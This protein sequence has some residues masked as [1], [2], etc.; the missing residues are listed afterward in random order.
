VHAPF[1]SQV[2]REN[3]NALLAWSRSREFGEN[4]Q[5][6][7]GSDVDDLSAA[8]CDHDLAHGLQKE[9]SVKF[10]SMTYFIAQAS[11]LRLSAPEA[12]AL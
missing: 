7:N 4:T 2:L 1:A 3:N 9:I 11:S 5:S 12:P 10:V 6:G 8:L